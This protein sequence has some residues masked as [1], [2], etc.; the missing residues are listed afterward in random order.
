MMVAVVGGEIATV[1]TK[2]LLI[3]TSTAAPTVLA[4][5]TTTVALPLILVVTCPWPEPRGAPLSN[6]RGFGPTTPP[7]KFCNDN[8]YLFIVI[9][10]FT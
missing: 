9:H 6:V 7:S 10:M 3:D 2:T 8:D 5:E 4:V 1:T